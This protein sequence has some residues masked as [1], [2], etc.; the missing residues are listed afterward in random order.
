MLTVRVRT[1]ALARPAVRR[2]R[3]TSKPPVRGG[4]RWWPSPGK[5][6]HPRP[7]RATGCAKRFSLRAATT[8]EPDCC[9]RDPGACRSGFPRPVGRRFRRSRQ[10]RPAVVWVELVRRWSSSSRP[11]RLGGRQALVERFEARPPVGRASRQA[12]AGQPGIDGAAPFKVVA[13]QWRRTAAI[14]QGISTRR[15]GPT[16]LRLHVYSVLGHVKR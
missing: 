9:C 1:W 8:R 15:W 16:R 3:S 5:G 2:R 14:S 12:T 11:G 7:P 10:A 13:E 4:A 6:T